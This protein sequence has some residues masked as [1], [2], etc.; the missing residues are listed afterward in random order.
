MNLILARTKCKGHKY[1]FC[2]YCLQG[3]LSQKVLDNHKQLCSHHHPQST[4][5]PVEGVNDTLK[6]TEN[7]FQLRVPFCIYAD[8]EA[9]PKDVETCYPDPNKS[10][11]T[12]N[13]KFEACFLWISSCLF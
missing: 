4:F 9:F 11:I 5:F 1:F 13:T 8:F 10:S 6:F 3:F 7:K 2:R 12:C